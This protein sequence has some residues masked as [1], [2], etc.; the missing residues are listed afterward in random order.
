MVTDSISH[1]LGIQPCEIIYTSGASEANNLAIKGIA[2]A[3][4]NYG[5]HIIS[6][7]LEH[8]TLS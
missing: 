7:T 6:T 5:R 3:R 4:R 1:L 8:A 2:R